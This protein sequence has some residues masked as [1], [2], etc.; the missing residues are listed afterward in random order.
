MILTDGVID[1]LQDTID[2]LVEASY[3]PLS[4]I[5]IGIGNKDFSN[6]N[7]Y[8]HWKQRFFKYGKIR[9]R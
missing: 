9:W 7:N 8:W 6:M 3:L 4:V 5:I 1:D 2:L